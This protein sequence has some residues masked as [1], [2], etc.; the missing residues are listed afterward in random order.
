DRLRERVR[1]LEHHAD[2]PSD[3]DRVDAGT[4]NRIAVELDLAG[5]LAARDQL[6]H[7]VQGPQERRLAAARGSDQRGHVLAD[8]VEAD[9]PDGLLFAIGDGEIADHQLGRRDRLWLGGHTAA[10][11]LRRRMRA[12]TTTAAMLRVKVSASSTRTVA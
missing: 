12:R 7:P 9:G 8:D 6:V 10:P 11:E 3:R 5:D 4:V 2:P 1:P